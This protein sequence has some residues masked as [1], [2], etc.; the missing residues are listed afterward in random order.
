M[1][2]VEDSSSDNDPTQIV[3]IANKRKT[4]FHG[5]LND[6]ATYEHQPKKLA[7]NKI[8]VSDPIFKM[9]LRNT[10]KIRD[11]QKDLKTAPTKKSQDKILQD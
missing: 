9:K 10:S 3:K 1:V 4:N 8:I 11:H 5:N 6:H 7:N 2:E